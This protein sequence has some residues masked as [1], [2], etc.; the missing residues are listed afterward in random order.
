MMLTLKEVHLERKD[1]KKLIHIS[2]DI[3]DT[4]LLPCPYL[5]RDIVIYRYGTM[6]MHEFRH[7]QIETGIIHQN[8][9]IGVPRQNVPFAC[10]HVVQYRT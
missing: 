6:R 4:I 8:Q 2:F 5:G 7:R 9:H 3:L 1:G 10:L